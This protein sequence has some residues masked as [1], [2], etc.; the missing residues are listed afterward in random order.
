MLYPV[1]PMSSLSNLL[2]TLTF[3][4][5]VLS[6][7]ALVAALRAGVKRRYPAVLGYLG[8][9]MTSGLGLLCLLHVPW[10][11]Q[12]GQV[13]LILRDSLFWLLYVAGTVTIVFAVREIFNE[14]MLPLAGLRRL[15]SIVFRWVAVVSLL[16]TVFAVF[17][18]HTGPH[19]MATIGAQLMKCAS[20]LE[21]CLL[22]FL[23][24]TIHTLGR[25][26]RSRV[27]GIAIGFSIE[28]LTQLGVA[29]WLGTHPE[30]YMLGGAI[31]SSVTLLSVSLWSTYFLFPEK[32]KAEGK[33][34][35]TSPLMR[36]NEIAKALGHNP[37]HVAMGQ[38]QAY[39][40]QDVEKVVERVMTKNSA[41]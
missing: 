14:L 41:G 32:G 3:L 28:A 19:R 36:W 11:S 26:I 2:L 40:L 38:S 12:G 34:P 1:K 7:I 39:F 8:L 18:L 31:L 27:F 20:I 25:S 13:S 15:G 21:L 35:E 16:V 22:L 9:R 4:E 29:I 23:G 30:G 5:P 24:L 10:F 33:L 6:G 37:P 17:P